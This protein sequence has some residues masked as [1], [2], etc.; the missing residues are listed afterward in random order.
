MPEQSSF[1]IFPDRMRTEA[2]ER[3]ANGN[4]RTLLAEEE[5]KRAVRRLEIQRLSGPQTPDQRTVDDLNA[6][7]PDTSG[8]PKLR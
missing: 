8:L 7:K 6:V 3:A 2:A 5:S 4:K 1:K